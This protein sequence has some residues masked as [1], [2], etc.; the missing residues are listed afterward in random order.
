[1]FEKEYIPWTEDLSVGLQEIDEQHKILINLI[2]RL[3]NEAI[4]KRADKAIIAEII[5]EL[6]QYTIV[7]FTVEESL[8]RIFDYPEGEDHQIHHDQL[9]KEVIKFRK[10]FAEGTP[11]DIELMG[12]LKK[13]ITQHIM[14]DDQKYTPFFLEKGFKAKWSKQKSW[15]GK[16][17]D[18]L[19]S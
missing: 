11:I 17:W 15:V 5:D 4:L 9:K 8:F 10:K 16:I 19:R 12:F 1:M 13:W 6:I 2:N 3:F 14:V 7:H 18:S